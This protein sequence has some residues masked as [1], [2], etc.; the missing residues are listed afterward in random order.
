MSKKMR[1]RLGAVAATLATVTLL[2]GALASQAIADGLPNVPLHTTW[3]GVNGDFST[4]VSGAPQRTSAEYV[5]HT[6]KTPD[7]GWA[8][9]LS[10]VDRTGKEID[11]VYILH[12]STNSATLRVPSTQIDAGSTLVFTWWAGPGGPVHEFQVPIRNAGSGSSAVDHQM[13]KRFDINWDK[14]VF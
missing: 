11:S 13:G 14:G 8:Q 12:G 7:Y 6:N 4:T 10:V 2:S 9:Q 1:S 5:L 3:E